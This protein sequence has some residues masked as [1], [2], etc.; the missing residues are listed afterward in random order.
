MGGPQLLHSAPHCI[1]HS[2]H[3]P[4][5]L[6][7]AYSY[8][9][10]PFAS[11]EI[12]E[13]FSPSLRPRSCL[14]KGA[15]LSKPRP[16]TRSWVGFCFCFGKYFFACLLVPWWKVK[17]SDLPPDARLFV[18]RQNSIEQFQLFTRFHLSEPLAHQNVFLSRFESHYIPPLNSLL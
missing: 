5:P 18:V 17:I 15:R 16:Q 14:P 7:L 11:G 8:F 13:R 10:F 2:R 6:P 9:S 4:L 3:P 12:S 1:R